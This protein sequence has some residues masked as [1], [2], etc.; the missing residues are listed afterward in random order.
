MGEVITPQTEGALFMAPP[1]IHGG[2]LENFEFLRC[3]LPA[4]LQQLEF[5]TQATTAQLLQW[6]LKWL[7]R[8]TQLHTLRTV[9]EGYAA[10]PWDGVVAAVNRLWP[11]LTICDMVLSTS[12]GAFPTL[13][14]LQD[15]EG[16]DDRILAACEHRNAGD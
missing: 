3:G 12:A 16:L 15:L 9:N 11:K 8:F 6:E 10:P 2:K 1:A 7:P 5:P 13:V 14:Y 4:T